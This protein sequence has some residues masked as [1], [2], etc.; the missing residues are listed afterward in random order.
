[1]DDLNLRDLLQGEEGGPPPPGGDDLSGG[2]GRGAAGGGELPGVGFS[3][4][5]GLRGDGL[6]PVDA[7]QFQQEGVVEERQTLDRDS[8]STRCKPRKRVS[9]ARGARLHDA[10]GVG[11]P[12]GPG[13]RRTVF[14]VGPDTATAAHASSF[15]APTPN[16]PASDSRARGLASTSTVDFDVTEGIG[17]PAHGPMDVGEMFSSFPTGRSE[18]EVTEYVDD[19]RVNYVPA[20][21]V[22]LADAL[23]RGAS[24]N[25]RPRSR[26]EGADDGVEEGRRTSDL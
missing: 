25:A 22:T 11:P 23:S 16:R 15:I 2:A 9:R 3:S 20:V 14:N 12:T 6:P 24:L 18:L 10:Q 26:D 21:M 17:G 5:G 7:L 19:V 13:T 8:R 1:M 4:G